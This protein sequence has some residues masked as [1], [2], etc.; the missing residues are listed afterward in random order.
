MPPRGGTFRETVEMKSLI[1]AVIATAGIAFAGVA[2]A[3]ADLAQK[4]CGS[5][6]EL[7]KKKMG[8]SF[9]DIAKKYKGNATAE[10]D[11]IAKVK[12]GKGHPAVKVSDADLT[13]IMKWVLA[14]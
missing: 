14:Q 9:K 11:L 1:V 7:D 6:H 10:A 2:S 8:P 12:S 13:G 4:N 5:C 3:Q